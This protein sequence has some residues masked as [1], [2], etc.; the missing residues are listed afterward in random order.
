MARLIAENPNVR[1]FTTS[2]A[3]GIVKRGLAVPVPLD[4]GDGPD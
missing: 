4:V 2:V 3:L 1:R